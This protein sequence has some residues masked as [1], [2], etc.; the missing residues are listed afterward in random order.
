MK[1]AIKT[2]STAI[3]RWLA[4]YRMRS[5]EI[6]LCG[7]YD[8][9]PMVRDELTRQRMQLAIREMSLALCKARADYIALLPAGQRVVLDIA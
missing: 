4:L 6:N 9:L 5:I 7:A 2:A 1:T 3:R 8:T